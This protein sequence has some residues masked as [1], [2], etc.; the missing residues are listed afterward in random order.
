MK[1]PRPFNFPLA[2]VAAVSLE[3]VL[4]RHPGGGRHGGRS[5]VEVYRA[6]LLLERP[7]RAI[8]LDE[9]SN[10]RDARVAAVAEAVA[11]F[12]GVPLRAE[13]DEDPAPRR[14]A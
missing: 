4:E 2:D 10:G 13:P 3:R 12:L 14:R 7:R 11:G 8:T 6:R 9:T 5:E 1:T